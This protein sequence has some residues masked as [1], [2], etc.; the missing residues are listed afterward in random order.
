[1]MPH[2]A[3]QS[4]P[5][6]ICVVRLS[7]IGDTCHALAVI[8]R[9]QDNW[10]DARITWIIGKTEASL[11]S[12]IEDVEFIVFDKSKGRHAYD[13]VRHELKGRNFDVALCMHASMRVNLLC[14]A[15]PTAVRL[16]FDRARARDSQWLFTN[17]RIPAAENEHALEAM[18]SFATT[19]GAKPTPLRWDLPLSSEATHYAARFAD[20]RRPVVVISPCSSQR[21]RNFRNWSV[22]NYAGIVRHLR[23]THDCSVVLT[24]GR[25]DLEKDYGAQLSAGADDGVIDL[26]G[27]SSLQELAA[28]I[29][30]AD[31]VICPDSGPAHV[32]TAVGT[33]VIGLY[34]TS[35]P[36]RTGP[37]LSRDLTVSRYD[38]AVR[39]YLGK[40]SAA[41]RWGTRVRHPDAMNLITIDDVISK[42]DVFLA[43]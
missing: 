11:M 25:S 37:Y 9:L 34:A 42:I 40:D 7:A 18:M 14:R 20:C 16:G 17:N 3:V 24:G 2:L 39:Q 38:E 23:R 10:P 6:D 15:I 21:S 31:L 13:E 35:N 28:V 5:Q 26:I 29:R 1:M 43:K 12:E 19:I 30:T 8:R 4:K 32:A 41:L 22:D 33:P 36:A 27:K